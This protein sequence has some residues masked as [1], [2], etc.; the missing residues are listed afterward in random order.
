[1]RLSSEMP[2]GYALFDLDHTILPFDTQ[3]LFCNYVLQQEG[4]RRI[5][6]AWFLLSL[7]L[8]ALKIFNL[9][10][11]KRVFAS[12]LFGMKKETLDRYVK[13]F[14]E[15]DFDKALYPEVVAEVERHREEGR[16]LIL[17]SASPDF[18]LAGISEKL[19][20]DH[21]I[22]TEMTVEDTMPMLPKILG[23]NNKCDA[24]IVAMRERALISGE[25]GM[26]AN[27]WAYSDSLAD[28]PL[29]SIAENGVMIHPSN[30][31]AKEGLKQGWRTMT[32]KR[33]Y[34][35]KWGCRWASAIQAMGFYRLK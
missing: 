7:P 15:S 1:M 5:Y 35:G 18:Y 12:Y 25:A 19:G 29:L 24:K 22:G 31:L 23:P 2:R 11:M 26:L 32:P 28:I 21:H 4:W 33:P 8:V 20:F 3:A 14:L 27:T 16:T 34:K 9:R 13:E 6:L 17:N 30:R 10:M